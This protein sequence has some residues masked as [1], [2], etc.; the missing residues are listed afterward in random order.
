MG[1]VYAVSL[2]GDLLI[3]L[4]DGQLLPGSLL[5]EEL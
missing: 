1:D 5:A 2:E 4:E 3:R